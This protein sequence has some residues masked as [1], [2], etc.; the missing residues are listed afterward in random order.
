MEACAFKGEGLTA[1]EIPLMPIPQWRARIHE[2]SAALSRSP[3]AHRLLSALLL[4]GFP[5]IGTYAHLVEPTWLRVRRLTLPL[6]N[7]PSAFGGFRLVHLSDLHV[8]SPVPRWFLQRVVERVQ[9]LAPDL[10]VLTGDFVHTRPEGMSGL[11][12]LLSKLRAPAGVFAVL[13]NHDYAINYPG[14]VGLPGVEEVVIAGLEQAGIVV[15]RNNW[16]PVTAGQ[17]RFALAG[18]DELWSGRARTTPV[19]T[20]PSTFSRVVLSHNPDLVQYLPENSFDLLLC[21]HTHGGQVR[22]PP[23]PPL[24][25]STVN[26]R[27]WGGLTEYGRGWVFVSRGIGYTWR[28][29]FASRPECVEITLTGR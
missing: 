8:G 12:T 1:D 9:A 28:V 20:I 21:G 5:G 7:L 25:T 11:T 14:H 23:F 29:R 17:S 2:L 15:L 19:Q 10:I 13:G 22:I 24:V 18:I 16:T 4:V 6:H 26:R 27:L 3:V